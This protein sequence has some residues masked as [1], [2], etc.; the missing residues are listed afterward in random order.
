MIEFIH[1]FDFQF[2]FLALARAAACAV[3]GGEFLAANFLF[4]QP[5]FPEATTVKIHRSV[6]KQASARDSNYGIGFHFN[7][8]RLSA[9]SRSKMKRY[10]I[11]SNN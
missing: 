8:R 11:I 3:F 9:V 2:E 5:H 4:H 10:L 1:N 6:V 7:K